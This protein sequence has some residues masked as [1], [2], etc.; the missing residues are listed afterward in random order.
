[1]ASARLA[2]TTG[3]LTIT[4]ARA[5]EVIPALTALAQQ[6]GYQLAGESAP[7]PSDEAPRAGWLARHPQAAATAASGALLLA[8]LVVG[9][10][11]GP[12]WASRVLYG[13]AILVGAFPW[14]APAGCR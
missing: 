11:G 3:L 5:H 9:W 1:M 10:L 14:P 8:A 6:M 2:Y 12:L 13:L 4:T 7:Q